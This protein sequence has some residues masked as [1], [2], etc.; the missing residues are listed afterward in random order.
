MLQRQLCVLEQHQGNHSAP[1]CAF[2]KCTIKQSTPLLLLLLDPGAWCT[3]TTTEHT[4][5][6]VAVL[7]SLLALIPAATKT[8]QPLVK[9]SHNPHTK[10]LHPRRKCCCMQQVCGMSPQLCNTTSPQ[11]AADAAQTAGRHH[12]CLRTGSSSLVADRASQQHDGAATRTAVDGSSCG[13]CTTG[14]SARAP[15]SQA[16]AASPAAPAAACCSP[17]AACWWPVGKRHTTPA[18]AQS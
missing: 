17:C 8:R 12:E 11:P 16:T 10:Q 5:C 1:L 15:V 6:Y 4:R 9:Q 3:A 18:P 14:V 2:F 7:Q 13:S